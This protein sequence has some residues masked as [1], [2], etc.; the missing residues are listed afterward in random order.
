V[1]IYVSPSG[2]LIFG[3]GF[4][5]S[6][7]FINMTS[8][9]IKSTDLY[10]NVVSESES[11]DNALKLKSFFNLYI[12]AG[13]DFGESLGKGLKLL[14]RY[15]KSLSDISPDGSISKDFFHLMVGYSYITY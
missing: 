3:G 1:G 8:G 5:L 11:G 10:G 14:L 9:T 2:G 4:S 15:S 12:D 13:Y 7:P 6:V